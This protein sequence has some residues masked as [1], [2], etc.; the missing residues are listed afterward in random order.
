MTKLSGQLTLEQATTL[1]VGE[2]VTPQSHISHIETRPLCFIDG[3]G[4]ADFHQ[5][6]QSFDL[7]VVL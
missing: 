4:V 6:L 7:K 5:E 1:A 3:H 2:A